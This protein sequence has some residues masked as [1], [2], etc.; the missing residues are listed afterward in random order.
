MSVV[1]AIKYRDGVA[2]AADK[3]ATGGHIKCNNVKKLAYYEKSN[4]GVGV[5]GHLRDCNIMY[6]QEELQD[7]K[8]ILNKTPIDFKYVVSKIVPTVFSIFNQCNRIEKDNEVLSLCSRMLFCTSNNIYKIE[9]DGGVVEYND[10]AA[11]G[12]GEDLVIGFLETIKDFHSL[13]KEQVTKILEK[14]IKQSCKNDVYINDN[15]D[16]IYL[17]K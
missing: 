11:I 2:M 4:T 17:E 9:H 8:D 3:Q 1:V 16:Y 12:C 14:C 7:A 15:I 10:W 5:V 6:V 13:N